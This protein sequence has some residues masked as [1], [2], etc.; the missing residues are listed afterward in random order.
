MAD[1]L[2]E[3][4][5]LCK[6]TLEALEK[7]QDSHIEYAM[8]LKKRL[9]SLL[10]QIVESK[11]KIMVRSPQGKE[12]SNEIMNHASKLHEAVT[13]LPNHKIDAEIVKEVEKMLG[14]V[15]ESVKKLVIFWKSF[16]YVTT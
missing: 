14:R 11:K 9:Q 15:E 12:I 3:A 1:P 6:E 13:N 2:T 10:N 5:K 7:L 16:E 4:D 8:S